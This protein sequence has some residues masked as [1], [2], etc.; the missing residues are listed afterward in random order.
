[1]EE[2]Y[3]SAAAFDLW[4]EGDAAIKDRILNHI[5]Q[6][7]TLNGEMGADI[8]A[9]KNQHATV[10]ASS[11]RWSSGIGAIV[12]AITSAIITSMRGH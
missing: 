9:L 2:K 3:L 1:M 8:A 12:S 11:A 5:D 7:H 6:Q 10:K 4:A